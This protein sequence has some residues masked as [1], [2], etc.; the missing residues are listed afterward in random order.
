MGILHIN[1]VQVLLNEQLSPNKKDAVSK[2]IDPYPVG[3]VRVWQGVKINR[4]AKTEITLRKSSIGA[5]NSEEATERQ[6]SLG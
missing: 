5:R 6:P 3:L 4:R 1:G 2:R